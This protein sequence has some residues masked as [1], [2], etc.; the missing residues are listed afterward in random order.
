MKAIKPV[1]FEKIFKKSDEF[2]LI[3]DRDDWETIHR[4]SFDELY[5][6]CEKEGN[7]FVAL[8]NPC[9]EIWLIGHL[10]DISE[11]PFYDQKLILEN[12]R[13]SSSKNYIDKFLG[14]LQG[15]GYNKRA[16]PQFFC[17]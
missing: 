7:F 10:I 5:G 17:H 14:D 3:I 8:S 6:E 13:V 12:A 2:W 15:R 1:T 11:I 16:N 9:F 4:H